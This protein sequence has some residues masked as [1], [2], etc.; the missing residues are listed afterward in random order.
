MIFEQDLLGRNLIGWRRKWIVLKIIDS[1]V[2]DEMIAK[3]HYS[4]KATSNRFLSMGVYHIDNQNTL[5]GCVQLGYGIRPK[6][7]HTWGNDV[8]HD[9]SVE[10][11]RMWLSDELPKFS[12]TVVLGALA[13]Y[14]HRAYPKLKYILTYSDGTVGNQGTIYKAGNYVSCGKL[15]ADFYILASGERVHPVSMWHRHGSRAWELMQKLYP[16]I[17]KADGFQFRFIYTLR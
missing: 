15:K 12:E 9:N 6:M 4:G 16:G 8:S 11:D 2:A 13:K 14:L 5:L 17:K 1:S 3:N 10:F 7:K